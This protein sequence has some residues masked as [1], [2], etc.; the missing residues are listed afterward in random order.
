MKNKGILRKDFMEENNKSSGYCT[1]TY[2]LRLYMDHIDYLIL[3]Q[4]IYNEIILKYYDLLLENMKFLN[5]S[6]QYC[7]RELEKMTIISRKGIIPPNYI[8][9]DLP[10]YFRRAAINHA[11]GSV[12]SYMSSS[13]NLQE[14]RLAK[15]FNAPLLYYKG[16][17]KNLSNT[18]VELK[19]WNGE[20]WIW[21]KAKING[22]H[23][24]E[25]EAMSP[26]LV[27][28]SKFV[29]MHLPVRKEVKDVTPVKVRMHKE[30]IN[31]LS[32][33]F[34]NTNNFAICIV[35]DNSGKFINAKFIKG[36]NEYKNKTTKILSKIK[37]DRHINKKLTQKDHKNYWIKLNNIYTTTAHKIS[38]KIIDYAKEN[39]VEVIAISEQKEGNEFITRRVGKYSPIYLRHK[40]LEFLKYKAFKE[41]ILITEQRSNYTA[42]RCYKCRSKIIRKN[43]QECVCENGHKH[44]YYFNTSMNVGLM[45]LKKFG[46]I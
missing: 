6:N 19:V 32:I 3:T 39:N 7:L 11:I 42:N 30:N 1:I 22:R 20:D 24:N 40:I 4:K 38:K 9:I 41:S 15:S 28:N 36:G 14:S 13:K 34:S 29:M 18:S 44:N 8:D 5:L 33:S 43:T 45:S 10:V 23:F 16:M 26:T 27:I 31:I 35:M 37:I 21:N 2:K 46:N 17:Y 12:R 25:E